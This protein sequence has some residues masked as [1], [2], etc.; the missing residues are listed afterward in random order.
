M[1]Y[2]N[3]HLVSWDGRLSDGERQAFTSLIVPQV[4][5]GSG[6]SEMS[7]GLHVRLIISPLLA[8]LILNN[9]RSLELLRICIN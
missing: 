9:P 6:G 7:H 2:G 1:S 8:T 4:V 3:L 5:T